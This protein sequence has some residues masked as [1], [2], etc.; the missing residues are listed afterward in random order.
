[1]ADQ[2]I[3]GLPKGATVRP[4]SQ[5][6]D[7]DIE[8]LPEGATVRPLS[9]P[10]ADA[11]SHTMTGEDTM[12]APKSTWDAFKGAVSHP[13]NYLQN[14]EQD[15]QEGGGRTVVGRGLGHMQSGSMTDTG[16]KAPVVPSDAVNKAPLKSMLP[17]VAGAGLV[18]GPPK[19]ARGLLR[20]GEAA[21]TPPDTS[22][23][24]PA[25]LEERVRAGVGG[26][27]EAAGGALELA[28]PFMASPT[29]IP[30]VV[31]GMAAQT[32]AQ[33]ALGVIPDKIVAPEYKEAAA[34]V[35]GLVGA[36][37]D[38]LAEKVT[39][40]VGRVIEKVRGKLPG[41]PKDVKSANILEDNLK[42]AQKEFEPVQAQWDAHEA[43]RQ[44]G[45]TAPLK[46]LKDY[47]AKKN[48]VV[49]AQAALDAHR[50]YMASKGAPAP[51][52]E[53]EIEL[54]PEQQEAQAA[55]QEKPTPTK[56]ENDAKLR[57]LMEQI[58][59]TEKP[60]PT[61]Q[62]VKLP[63]QVQSETFPQEP[64]EAPKVDTRM[65]PLAGGQGTVGRRLALPAI[66]E[67]AQASEPVVA[68]PEPPPIQTAPAPKAGEVPNMRSLKVEETGKV[69][70]TEDTAEGRLRKAI[71][72]S[73]SGTPKPAPAEPTAVEAP[74]PAAEVAAK[75]GAKKFEAAKAEENEGAAE[76]AARKQRESE[77]KEAA[78]KA[79]EPKPKSETVGTEE[80]A[81][82]DTDHFAQ[83]KKELP[84]GTLSEQAQ[85]AQQLKDEAA[86]SKNGAAEKES[87]PE[88]DSKAEQVISQHSDQDLLRFAQKS[89]INTEGYDFAKRDDN[90]HRVDRNRL[91]KDLLAKLPAEAKTNIARLS[92]KFNDKDSTLWT[93]AE[94]SNLS[95]AQR[96]R[97]IMQEHEGGTKSV[98]GGTKEPEGVYHSGEPESDLEMIR[99]GATP[100]D[101]K[102]AANDYN[103][104]NK[105]PEV[106]PGKVD[107]NPRA[108]DISDAYEKMKHDPE[109]PAVKKSYD[110]LIDDV[111]KQWKYAQDKMGI[112]FEPTPKD[113][114]KSEKEMMDDINENKR[115]KVFTGGQELNEGHPLAK[116]DP[117]TG[118]SYNT[119][120]R[121]VHDLFG[122]GVQ[123]HDFSEPGE[124]SAWNVHRQMMS[125]EAVPA[126]TTETR[127]QT[128]W[129][130]NHGDTPGE[131]AEQKAGLLPEEFHSPGAEPKPVDIRQ[132][133]GAHNANGG[134]TYN[135]TQ[136][137]MMGKDAYAVAGSYPK[138]SKTID[139][140]D[141]THEQLKD[142]MESPEVAKVLKDN[143]DAS[144]GTWA[145]DGKTELEITVTPKD[146]EAAIELGKKNNQQSIYDLK[147]GEEIKTGGTGK[148]NDKGSPVDEFGNP[149]VSGGAPDKVLDK[150]KTKVNVLPRGE[151][152]TD[153]LGDGTTRHYLLSDGSM[154]SEKVPIHSDIETKVGT[155]A[156]NKAKG[157]RMAGP[158]EFDVYSKPTAQQVSELAR[159]TKEAN[160]AYGGKMYWTIKPESGSDVGGA[161]SFGDF[162]RDLDK[163]YPDTGKFPAVAEKHLL[164]E[165]KQGVSKSKAGFDR[166][167]DVLK[168]LPPVKE[169]TDAAIAG[170][171]ERK[172]YQRSTQA[173]D[174]MSKEVPEYFDQEGDRDKFIGI[175][176]AGSPQQTIA[177]NMREALRVWT[178]YVDSGRPTGQALVKLLTKPSAEGGFTLSGAKVPNAMKALAGEPL[179]PD[180]TKNTNFKVP[181]FRD[182]LTG[183]LNRVTNDGWMALF[184]GLDAKDIE[185]AHSYH[186]IS[187]MTRAA[188]DE[189]GWEPAEAQAAIWAFIKTLTER[190]KDA[191]ENPTIM[192]EYSEDFSDIIQHDPETKA[193]LKDM[194]I[195]HGKL[196]ERLAREVEAK[197]E[198]DSSGGR[199]SAEN[200]TRRAAERVENA[201]GK[202]TIPAPKTGLLNFGAPED[203]GRGSAGNEDE[204]TEFN[205]E[206]FKTGTGD[207][208]VSPLSERSGKTILSVKVDGERAGQ[209]SL[210]PMP[211]LG[212]DAVEI[213]TSQ[214]GEAYRGKGH[215]TEM[216]RKV[217]AYAKDKGIKTIYSDDQVSTKA[218]NVWQSLVRKGEAKWDSDVKRYKISVSPMKKIT[219]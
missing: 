168:S 77:E 181:S 62:N 173:F 113:P 1:M 133:V 53:R 148:F 18:Q 11:P 215:G 51:A 78:A 162:Q 134:T 57:G 195:D 128:S 194:G 54:S 140:E 34:N 83:A 143:P 116:V 197:P 2:E 183:M 8:G 16:F 111:K 107:K 22:K 170:A 132:Q 165:E 32:A 106:Q 188:A 190:G 19:I 99:R 102:E 52:P 163:S 174:A 199:P 25:A 186:P 59:P 217:I 210:T 84:N 187:V 100:L 94:R 12:S 13:I 40:K 152:D 4:I 179:W 122:H 63:G 96:S 161:G 101:L 26:A 204:A 79:E 75:E 108:K 9:T 39:P 200:S 129:F 87:N 85:R 138:L 6:K 14:V 121:A 159:I 155:E 146:R 35:A 82:A 150:I 90:R 169:F 171:G 91:V 176:A 156:L 42:K 86:K 149:L 139:S 31:A 60:E 93:E 130:F 105:L 23:S 45:G 213:S 196:A 37:A 182:N 88:H 58:A 56:E 185:K 191:A 28:S 206:K 98:A 205:P 147:K 123:A 219:T 184:S 92:D 177:E 135:P 164:P 69:I 10:H 151:I 48:A 36:G 218:D 61:P 43:V 189:L 125:P 21:M 209:L 55:R 70:D 216:Y 157:I 64:T 203:E 104:A 97:A 110:A 178:N 7:T 193:L 74:K 24:V 65:R 208:A 118:E 20:I 5:S 202:G 47:E 15:V 212:K 119:M 112:K 41:A 126:M 192:R 145:H 115:L 120:F 72:E 17:T 158:Q 71:I 154:I 136:G 67:T 73:L 175:L 172:W 153:T 38:E 137:N 3:E 141:L 201:R 114:Y 117:N 207:V 142:Y 81:K 211:D 27:N 167:V 103:K 180:I 214:L 160:E 109:D 46:V 95:K 198:T 30:R 29:I 33:K 68:K 66:G 80:G 144:V 89:G 124:E 44:Q 166:F 76:A 50:E 131:F 127:G 49:E